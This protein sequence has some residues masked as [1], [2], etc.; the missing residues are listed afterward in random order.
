M[1]RLPGSPNHCTASGG[2][3]QALLI[4]VLQEEVATR[5]YHI[6]CTAR[7]GSYQALLITVLQGEGG[8]GYKCLKLLSDVP[9]WNTLLQ[10]PVE[11]ETEMQEPTP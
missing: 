5:L 3:Y 6:H 11:L 9:A 1:N 2:S 10:L 7:G 8:G 4:N